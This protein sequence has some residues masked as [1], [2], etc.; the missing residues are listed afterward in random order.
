MGENYSDTG[1]AVQELLNRFVTGGWEVASLQDYRESGTAHPKWKATRL[2][3]ATAASRRTRA[4][5]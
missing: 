4:D 2:L 3:T 5:I 1:H